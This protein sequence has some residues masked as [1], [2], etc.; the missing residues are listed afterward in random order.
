MRALAQAAPAASP[1]DYADAAEVECEAAVV[2]CASDAKAGLTAVQALKKRGAAVLALL[3]D[4]GEF[5]EAALVGA[6]EFVR[7]GLVERDLE[8]RLA[9]MVGW[10]RDKDA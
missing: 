3:P 1:I 4:D 5:D 2:D 8:T 9:S 7:I 10:A 6:D